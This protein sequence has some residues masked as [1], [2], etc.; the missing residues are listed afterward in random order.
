[1]D[2]QVVD[3]SDTHHEWLRGGQTKVGVKAKSLQ[4]MIAWSI[5]GKF[6]RGVSKSPQIN[7]IGAYEAVDQK[8]VRWSCSASFVIEVTF[9]VCAVA[10]I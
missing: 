8:R 4:F 7:F 1:M 5:T 10:L 3:R 6:V 9:S 2:S